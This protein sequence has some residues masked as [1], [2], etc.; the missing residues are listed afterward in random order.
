MTENDINLTRLK[1]KI[2]EIPDAMLEISYVEPNKSGRNKNKTLSEIL[3]IILFLAFILLIL[4]LVGSSISNKFSSIFH[5]TIIFITIILFSLMILEFYFPEKYHKN[6]VYITSILFKFHDIKSENYLESVIK[7]FYH[8]F[9]ELGFHS[10]N[11]ID[12]LLDIFEK[13]DLNIILSAENQQINLD[14]KGKKLVVSS[15]FDSLMKTLSDTFPDSIINSKVTEIDDYTL[16]KYKIV[17][18]TRSDPIIVNWE[19][20]ENK[21]EI[22]SG[23]KIPERSIIL[24]IKSYLSIFS[25]LIFMYFSLVYLLDLDFKSMIFLY[26]I[27]SLLLVIIIH[28]IYSKL[29][30]FFTTKIKLTYNPV[31]SPIYEKIYIYSKIINILGLQLNSSRFSKNHLG[32]YNSKFIWRNVENGD[33]VVTTYSDMT[34]VEQLQNTQL[35]L[36][37]IK[38]SRSKRKTLFVDLRNLLSEKIEIPTVHDILNIKYPIYKNNQVLAKKKFYNEFMS[39]ERKLDKKLLTFMLIITFSFIFITMSPIIS[40]LDLALSKNSEYRDTFLINEYVASDTIELQYN[41]PKEILSTVYFS[42][43]NNFE[44]STSVLITMNL[45]NKLI[46]EVNDT[47]LGN[48][49]LEW[50]KDIFPIEDSLLEIQIITNASI[51]VQLFQGHKLSTEKI[52]LVN[53]FLLS[54]FVFSI[55][56]PFE[57]LWERF[58]NPLLQELVNK[59][60]QNKKEKFN[61]NLK[62]IFLY[63]L[64]LSAWVLILRILES[65]DLSWHVKSFRIIFLDPGILP[66]VAITVYIILGLGSSIYLEERSSNTTINIVIHGIITLIFILTIFPGLVELIMYLL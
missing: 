18:S 49:L 22:T 16:S 59:K 6:V 27:I 57:N 50:H 1:S 4:S 21:Y 51:T 42:L 3:F 12:P 13:E 52:Y 2:N 8:L 32:P 45:Q 63:I 14:I 46:F 24:K 43:L 31:E 44:H 11:S 61:I 9:I 41:L 29:S 54:I 62:S 23:N 40:G 36:L 64:V 34:S 33:E 56:L 39:I 55:L 20:D 26:A 10:S 53:I 25:P 19:F 7:E 66:L 38:V 47:Y 35:L 60:F 58:V 17:E 5:I 48:N 28:L 15:F 30:N 65:T 37:E